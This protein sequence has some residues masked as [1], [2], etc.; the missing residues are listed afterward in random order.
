MERFTISMDDQLFEQFDKVSHARG[1]DNRSEAIRDL[2]RDYLETT[3]LEKDN[4]GYCIATLSY[5]YNHHQRDLA[6]QVTSAHHHHHDLSLSSMHVH[7]D[8]DNCLETTILRGTI[9]D[10]RRFANQMIA[11]NGV[12]HGKLHI[13][14]IEL[15]EELHPHSATPHTHCSPLT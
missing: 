1:Y 7:M 3:R 14:P 5:I 4:K 2:I 6:S 13:V 11:T 15:S 9:Q 10:V 8:H 12:R